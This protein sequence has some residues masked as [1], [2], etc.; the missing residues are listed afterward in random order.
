MVEDE[1]KPFNEQTTIQDAVVGDP[2]AE[3]QQEPRPAWPP[4]PRLRPRQGPSKAISILTITLILLLVAGG[5][6]FM[7]YAA[8]NQYGSALGAART[9]NVNSTVLS[10]IKSQAT[11]DSSLAQTAQPLATAQAQIIASATAQDLPTVTAQAEGDQA[12]ATATALGDMLTQDTAGS[13]DLLDPLSDNSLNYQWDTGY[14]DNNAT[15]CNFVNS[16]YEVQESRQ[17]F[18]QP[19]F[20]DATSFSRFVYQVTMTINAGNEGGIIFRGNKANGKYYVFRIDINGFYALDLYS[21]NTYTLLTSGVSTAISTGTGLSNDLTVVAD[22]NNLY[23]F[24]NET[25]VDGVSNNTLSV[26]QI[27]MAAID[28]GLPVTVDFTNAEVWKLT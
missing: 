7:I 15:G 8:T 25:Y 26:G 17:G 23:L 4:P 27:G 22:T 28:T 5:L 21:G 1:Q 2:R 24:V 14:A 19:C 18:L 13:P 16:D 6:G 3:T 20:A 12:T 9:L 11:V 10:E